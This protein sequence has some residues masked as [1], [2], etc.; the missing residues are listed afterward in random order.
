M[1]VKLKKETPM[2]STKWNKLVKKMNLK[3]YK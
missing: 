1:K 2:S 3:D